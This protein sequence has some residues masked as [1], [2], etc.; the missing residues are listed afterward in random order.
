MDKA[1]DHNKLSPAGIVMLGLFALHFAMCCATSLG[2]KL[3]HT[4]QNIWLIGVL[5]PMTIAW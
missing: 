4:E 2:L 5:G 1:I 3:T